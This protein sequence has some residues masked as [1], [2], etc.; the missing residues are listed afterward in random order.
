[1]LI[2][3]YLFINNEVI[4]ITFTKSVKLV[5]MFKHFF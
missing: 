4:K 2:P 3:K 1:M 5:A